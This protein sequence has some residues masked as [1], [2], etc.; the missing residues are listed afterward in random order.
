MN[1]LNH[2]LDLL[3][4]YLHTNRLSTYA[5]LNHCW[6]IWFVRFVSKVQIVAIIQL[7]SHR[8]Q[9]YIG[10]S[11]RGGSHT[12]NFSHLQLF[13]SNLS[14]L[15]QT[16]TS[17][18]KLKHRTNREKHTRNQQIW[19]ISV[20]QIQEINKR[21]YEICTY[22]YIYKYRNIQT[23]NAY[24]SM[25]LALISQLEWAHCRRPGDL[26]L[27]A[28]QP[29]ELDLAMANWFHLRAVGASTSGAKWGY[30]RFVVWRCASSSRKCFT[31]IMKT[32][33]KVFNVSR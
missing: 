7:S 25:E 21:E 11:S 29:A 20:K 4:S 22:I 27:L 19:T 9:N 15:K 12:D 8:I 14:I 24:F 13:Y 2:M 23:C 16:Q 28:Q 33:G 32:N 6:S 31:F 18:R 1:K 26:L 30:Y 10:V 17:Q 5:K 3:L